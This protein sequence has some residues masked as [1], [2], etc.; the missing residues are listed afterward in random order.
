[1]Y[2]RIQRFPRK[3]SYMQ[4]IRH[5]KFLRLATTH[6]PIALRGLRERLVMLA[7]L[8]C[9]LR[10]LRR[11]RL[12]GLVRVGAQLLD[13]RVGVLVTGDR[14]AIAVELNVT[15][16]CEVALVDNVAEVLGTVKLKIK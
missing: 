8:L 11:L 1:M 4:H 13:E 3:H 10:L 5:S 15:G 2:V 9:L 12:L 7:R 6:G 14:G 16:H